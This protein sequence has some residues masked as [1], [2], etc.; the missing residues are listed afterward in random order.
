MKVGWRTFLPARKARE[1]R[2][3]IS[4]QISEQ[5]SEKVPETSFQIRNFFSETSFIRRAVP[6]LTKSFKF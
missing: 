4:G 3:Q 1:I 5:I 2:G 6:L